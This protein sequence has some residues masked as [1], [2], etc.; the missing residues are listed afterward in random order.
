MFAEVG[1]E[2]IVTGTAAGEGFLLYRLQYGAGLNPGA[3]FQIG[4]DVA[5]PVT[6]GKLGEW[7][8]T[9]L[10][11]LYVLQLQVIYLDQTL[12]TASVVVDAGEVGP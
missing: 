5:T 9:G 3:W 1:E 12:K 4:E 8:T 6:A 11:G 7:D 2:V 10:D